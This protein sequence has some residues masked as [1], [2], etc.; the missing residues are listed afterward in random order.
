MQIASEPNFFRPGN[1]KI[2]S[3]KTKQWRDNLNIQDFSKALNVEI[4]A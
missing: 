2:S 3:G 1:E 4:V